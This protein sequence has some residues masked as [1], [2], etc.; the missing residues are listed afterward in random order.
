MTLPNRLVLSLIVTTLSAC[1]LIVP[2]PPPPPP[3]PPPPE[4][5]A[6]QVL[7]Q[8]NLDRG[9][10]NMIPAYEALVRSLETALAQNPEQPLVV[11]EMGVMALDR[12]TALGPR[13]VYGEAVT[14]PVFTPDG[15][16]GPPL[17]Q[18]LTQ[19]AMGDFLDDRDPSRPE[20]AN[21][22]ELGATLWRQSVYRPDGSDALGRPLFGAPRAGF[23]VITI[24]HLRRPCGLDDA[25]CQ[26]QGTN[27][28]DHFAATDG[29]GATWLRF[30]ADARL[31]PER[32]FH[33]SF[34]T[35][36][37]VDDESFFTACANVPG[38]PQGIVDLMEPSPS[39]YWH[40][41]AQRLGARAS[42]SAITKDLCA[43][44]GVP[45]VVEVAGLAKHLASRIAAHP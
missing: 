19:I 3:P 12:T 33:L 15:A 5:L 8:V 31:P 11:A 28:V 17:T 24:N 35:A 45:G 6:V 2:D 36:E 1:V 22:A 32:I 44:L 4:P 20:H 25:G 37:G 41:F 21:L 40:P 16:S 29:N 18:V 39:P 38:F 43:M 34:V 7:W 9:A 42:G 30:G 27:P 23:I 14:Q 13:L 26:L 10:V